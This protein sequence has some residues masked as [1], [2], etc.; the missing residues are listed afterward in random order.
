MRNMTSST[1]NTKRNQINHPLAEQR[2]QRVNLVISVITIIVCALVLR[3]AYLQVLPHTDPSEQSAKKHAAADKTYRTPRGSIVE[4][5]GALMAVDSTWYS[6]WI[7]PNSLAQVTEK[8]RESYAKKLSPLLHIPQDKLLEMLNQ[9]DKKYI[10]LTDS[11]TRLSID[12]GEA[13]YDLAKGY[14]WLGVEPRYYRV[15]PN[16]TLASHVLGIVDQENGCGEYGVE[17]YYDQLLQNGSP[18]A[19]KCPSAKRPNPINDFLAGDVAHTGGAPVTEVVEVG[20]RTLA[21]SQNQTDLVLTID[22]GIQYLVEKDLESALRQLHAQSGTVIVMEPKTGKILAMANK[23]DYDPNNRR[24][25]DLP[26]LMNPAVSGYYDPGSTFKIFTVANALKSGL[27]NPQSIVH[28]SGSFRHGGITVSNWDGAGHGDVNLT[29][30]LGFSLNT[31]AAYLN[32]K[33]GPRRVISYTLQLGF[34]QPTGIDLAGE[35]AG[36]VKVP[37]DGKW[38]EWDLVTNAYGQGISV[39]PIQLATAVSAVANGGLLMQPQ[40]VDTVLDHGVVRHRAPKVIRRVYSPEIAH[41]M[42]N[43]LVESVGMETEKALVPGWAIAGKTGTS[44]IYVN[45]VIAQNQFIGSF[46]GWAPADD[47]QFLV[48]IIIR[49]AEGENYWGSQSAAPL[50]QKVAWQLFHYMHIPPDQM[51]QAAR[52][53]GLPTP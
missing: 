46:V 50:F 4:R 15:Y 32:T 1:R 7:S 5:N 29:Q 6:V 25:S 43:M 36:Q 44:N 47:P 48:L 35:R 37:G 22:R 13:L 23:P 14:G 10:L 20:L 21:P 3:L 40:I 2:T 27:F 51:R 28:D 18:T 8:D 45:G 52:V 11:T 26:R 42:S 39:T 19:A 53:T 9:F 34:G 33:L 17:E 16:G 24:Q 41:E 30:V 12:D 31:M 38:H 49:D